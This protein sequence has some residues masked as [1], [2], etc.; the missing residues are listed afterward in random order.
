MARK[1]PKVSLAQPVEPR[2]GE[3]E[4]LFTT[5][6]DA[7]QA[8][9]LQLLSIRVDAIQPDPHQPRRTF[10]DE[11]LQE[12]AVS[13]QQDGVIQPIEVTE[14]GPE[15]YKIVHGERRWRAAEMAGLETIP[16]VV[17]RRDYDTI[18]R[19]VRQLAE[20]IQREDLNDV[21]RAAGLLRLRDLMQEELD[22]RPD[23]EIDP[24]PW[25]KTITWAKVGKRLG[26]TR[27][28]IHQLIQLL[29]LPEEIKADV[30][31]GNL[32]ERETR[33]YQGLHV[34]QQRDLHRARFRQELSQTELRQVAAHLKEE[35]GKTVN[36]A[37]RELRQPLPEP[38]NEPGLDT[39]FD[40]EAAAETLDPESPKALRTQP[41]SDEGVQPPRQTRPTS[42]D[43]LDYVR[44][45]LARVQRQELTAAERQEMIRLLELIR[46]DV[47]SLLTTLRGE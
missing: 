10:S 41:W 7:E 43:R 23:D 32:S 31:A 9:G 16:A 37:I 38:E 13:I 26:F 36:Q 17:R 2:S 8:S 4:K 28:R 34:R 46:Q 25:A 39:S 14:S 19:F 35:P 22:A 29:N 33:I 3:M 21:D 5:A 18:T 12:L 27:Q 44:G 45:H 30:R 40:Q 24:S 6:E 1:R 20:N 47:D 42:I 15:Q 11:S